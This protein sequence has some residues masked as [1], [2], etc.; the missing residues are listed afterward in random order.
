MNASSISH[1][2]K[3]CPISVI[4]IARNEEKNIQRCLASVMDWV[5]EIIVVV[6]GCTD[7]TVQKA[8]EL[9]ARV[10]EHPWMGYGAQKNFGAGL[11]AQ[12]WILS[13]DADEEVSPDLK[14]SMQ[15]FFS[16]NDAVA[17]DGT[18]FSRLV[19]FQR[20]W[21]RHGEWYPD[22]VVRLYRKEKGHWSGDAV[23][24]RLEI[25][26]KIKRVRGHLYHY[27]YR[28]FQEQL[29]TGL[30]YADLWVQEQRVRPVCAL[31]IFA[32]SLWRFFRG[33]VLKLGCLDGFLGLYI[34]LTQGFLTT[35]RY[36]RLRERCRR[37]GAQR[38]PARC[39]GCGKE[40]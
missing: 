9:G 13:L 5:Q 15:D 39:A 34:A 33:Y 26:G 12:P 2:Q 40:K 6:N 27:T 8:E 37:L 11:S 20:K 35:Y 10:V 36:A 16:A 28:S 1:P 24:E 21:I 3:V 7:A 32:R 17:Y 29:Q 19:Y 14:L 25:T 22:Y 4:V 18:N 31:E 23:H 38:A 30:K